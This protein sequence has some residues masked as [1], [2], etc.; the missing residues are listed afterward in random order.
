MGIGAG[1][2]ELELPVL[3]PLLIEAMENDFKFGEV[4]G[5]FALR[6]V[7]TYGLANTNFLAVRPQRTG[8]RMNLEV[9]I[10]IP[11]VFIEGYQKAEGAI[12]PYKVGGKGEG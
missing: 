5:R 11:K 6:D 9:D 12:G 4:T 3:D 7:K 10:E 1:I 8:G 2:P